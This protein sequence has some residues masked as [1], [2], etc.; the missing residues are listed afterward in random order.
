MGR[1]MS[2]EPSLE[3]LLDQAYAAVMKADYAALDGIDARIAAHLTQMGAPRDAAILSRLQQ[4][5]ARNA[6]CLQAA[7]RGIRSA[8]RRLEEV[9]RAKLGLATYDD[10]GRRVEAGAQHRLRERF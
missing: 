7:G 6:I 8:V 9:R 2:A 4:K 1:K 3:G 5:A 10:K